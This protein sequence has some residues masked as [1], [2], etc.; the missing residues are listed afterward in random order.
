MFENLFKSADT[1]AAL[2]EL[3]KEM[4]GEHSIAFGVLSSEIRN[5]LT[6]SNG[7]AV[8]VQLKQGFTHREIVH[9]GAKL[10]LD[11]KL[12]SGEYHVYRGVLDITG[13]DMWKLYQSSLRLLARP[14]NAD[15]KTIQKE[16]DVMK[17]AIAEAG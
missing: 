5:M 8:S 12:P 2:K 14:C 16:T 7:K 17:K 4:R 1:K 10:I 9:L 11:R 6:D 13:M 3:E 15:A